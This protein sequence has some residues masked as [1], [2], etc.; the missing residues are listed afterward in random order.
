MTD[1]LVVAEGMRKTYGR[2]GLFRKG[3]PY[4][5]VKDVSLS[6]GVG[7][8]LAIV[9]ESGAGKS[10]VGRMV[11][12]LIEPDSGSV[13][14]VGTDLLA[15][16]SK[17][18]RKIRPEMQMI[19][20]DPFSS[21][22]PTM[23]IGDSVSE[24][25]KVHTDLGADA[26]HHKVAELL[27]RV[28]LTPEFADR[29]PRECSGGQLQRIAIARAISTGPRLIVCDE[30]VA[31]L[32]LSIR[33]QILNLLLDLQQELGISYLF[34]SHDLSVVRHFAHRVAVMKSGEIVEQGDIEDVF[35]R[36]VE[37]YTRELL[38]AVPIPSFADD[39]TNAT[40]TARVVSAG[41]AKES[42]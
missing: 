20:Q 25:L 8:T 13:T 31:A 35:E 33:G 34:I 30:P 40:R 18:L 1:R 9:G 32:D 10:T 17:Q 4:V 6:V 26:R 2:Q 36:P 24:P 38:A 41:S 19:F 39:E 22:D 16:S 5:A 29:F 15:L 14:F 3:V 28:G 42:L 11:L 27:L 21:L 12:R 23:M 7:E 37:A